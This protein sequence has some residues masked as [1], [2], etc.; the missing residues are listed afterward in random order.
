VTQGNCGQALVS[1]TDFVRRLEAV[2]L[3]SD[4]KRRCRGYGGGRSCIED[5]MENAEHTHTVWNDPYESMTTAG[6]TSEK[7]EN[8]AELGIR[9]IHL[10]A[11]CHVDVTFG[12]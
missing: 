10:D 6:R 2:S 4:G 12:D 5:E 1:L 11:A 3:E 9:L 8:P 7:G